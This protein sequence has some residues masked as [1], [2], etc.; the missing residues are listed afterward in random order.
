MIVASLNGRNNGLETVVGGTLQ[1]KR[2]RS[3]FDSLQGRR[4]PTLP[5]ASGFELG[6]PQYI[7]GE[8]C[9]PL[10]GYSPD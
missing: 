5:N 9:D 3:A 6:W 10:P 7:L 4:A 2:R 1:I 8:F